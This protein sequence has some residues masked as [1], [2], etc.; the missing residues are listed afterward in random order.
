MRKKVT[1]L[2]FFLIMLVPFVFSDFQKAGISERENRRLAVFP[3]WSQ[4]DGTANP[5]FFNQLEKWFSDHVGF[6]EEFIQLDTLIAYDLFQSANQDTL[7]VGKDG[8]LFTT[9]WDNVEI[10]RGSNYYQ[11]GEAFYAAIT[12]NL[13]HY[14]DVLKE[15]DREFVL[16][17]APSKASV[18]T[19]NLPGEFTTGVTVVDELET[20]LNKN[21]DI[22]VINLKKTML[23]HKNDT[24][25]WLY[26][27]TDTHW[28]FLGADYGYREVINRLGEYGILATKPIKA[29]FKP[30]NIYAKCGDI[31]KQMKGE[32]EDL[33]E[34]VRLPEYEQLFTAELVTDEAELKKITEYGDKFEV[35]MVQLYENSENSGPSALLLGDSFSTDLKVPL[36][37]HFS[38][39]AFSWEY[40]PDESLFEITDPDVVMIECTE[41]LL[42]KMTTR[43]YVVFGE[44]N[45][46]NIDYYS[47]DSYDGFVFAV[48]SEENGQDDLVWYTA[49]KGDEDGYVWSYRGS[50]EPHSPTEY[51]YVHGYSKAADGTLTFVYSKEVDLKKSDEQ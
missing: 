2:V 22:K 27:K 12:R 7:V 13:M 11:K 23:E 26:Y 19:E 42:D 8:W 18:Y 17:L 39:L 45:S 20:Y 6:R 41:R 29:E 36:S 35:P 25:G 16:I 31:L 49:E 15:N 38:S 51:L 34:P 50:M 32:R 47:K 40:L 33:F 1:I 9:G 4:S 43:L 10:G 24:A 3:N 30:E 46:L 14:R 37:Q 5:D 48:W 28:N 44:D 21:T